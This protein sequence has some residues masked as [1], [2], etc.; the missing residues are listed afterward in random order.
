MLAALLLLVAVLI[1]V[2]S[3]GA[4]TPQAK[5]I[6]TLQKQVKVMQKQVKALKKQVT[7]VDT[8]ARIAFSLS[9]FDLQGTTCALAMVADTFQ[10]TWKALDNAGVSGAPFSTL[11]TP[12]VNDYGACTDIT[13]TRQTGLSL[14][15][16]I[17]YNSLIAYLYSP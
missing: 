6:K 7:T 4:A 13:L 9:V 2:S 1:P 14:P 17:A 11:I 8:E 3:A 15:S 10:A 16:W 5:Q 12:P